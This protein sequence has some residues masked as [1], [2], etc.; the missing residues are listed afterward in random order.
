MEVSLCRAVSNLPF[1]RLQFSPAANH[2]SSILSLPLKKSHNK[3][4]LLN[5]ATPSWKA[6][7]SEE[8]STVVNGQAENVSGVIVT[9]EEPSSEQVESEA[10]SVE[11]LNEES[12]SG[13]QLE[14]SEF[15]EKL[16]IKLDL[17]DSYSV[18][19]YGSGALVALWLA[20]AVIGA[21]DSIPLFPKVLEV[22]GLSYTIWFTSRYLIFK[23]N[24]DEL[25]VKIEELKE[26]IIG[27]TDE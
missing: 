9:V 10:S 20:S 19:L 25:L 15:L 6:T 4:G 23:E 11:V 27:S 1:H 14:I 8:D 16:K 26:Q 7:T 2:R 24:R 5:R 21:I 22:V 12:P 17:E 18:L 13:G 3:L